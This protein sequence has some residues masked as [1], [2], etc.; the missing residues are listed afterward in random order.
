MK[1]SLR[2][3]TR[4]FFLE[5]LEDRCVLSATFGENALV[6]TASGQLEVVPLAAGQS[7]QDLRAAYPSALSIEPD[8]RIQIERTPNDT[9]YTSLYAMPLIDAP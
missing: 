4:R 7:L 2:T 3:P 5:T 6:T 1:T 8:Y 9:S